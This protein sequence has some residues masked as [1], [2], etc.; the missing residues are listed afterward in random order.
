MLKYVLLVLQP[1]LVHA[2]MA[3]PIVKPEII[4][5]IKEVGKV[6]AIVV[7]EHSDGKAHRIALTGQ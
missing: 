6:E 4:T 3:V 2:V 1:D 5:A 7:T